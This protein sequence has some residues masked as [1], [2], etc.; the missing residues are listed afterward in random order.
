ME[1]LVFLAV[2]LGGL[3]F[4][5]ALGAV[6]WLLVHHAQQARKREIAFH[7]HWASHHG[8][9]YW[10]EEP[11]ALAVSALP[12]LSSGHS[13]QARNVFRGR[14]KGAHLHC[15]EIR[16]QTGSGDNESTHHFQVVAISLPA[17]RPALDIGHENF[18]TKRFAKDIEFENREFNDRFKIQS[19]SARFAYDVIHARTMEWMLTDWRAWSYHWRF[20]GPWLMTYRSGRL[21]LNEVFPYADFLHEVLDRVPKHVWTD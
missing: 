12:P 6:V 7:H 21:D 10:P 9:H 8:F 4:L 11:S 14:Y 17:T 2:P 20:E 3:A 1:T 19:L 13:R 15:F 16:Y 5:G 18:L